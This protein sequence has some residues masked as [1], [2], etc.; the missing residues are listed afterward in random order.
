[1]IRKNTYENMGNEIS[2]SIG[3][4]LYDNLKE[5][6]ELKESFGNVFK[7]DNDMANSSDLYTTVLAKAIYYKSYDRFQQYFD[8]V[9]QLTPADL[10]MPAGAGVYKIPKIVGT[11][12]VKIADG[13]VV[14]YINDG[15]D[16]ITLETETY[17]IGTKMTR[18]ILLRGAKGFIDKLLT[19]G[20]DGVM[21]AVVTD[22]VN[23]MAAAV[24]TANVVTGGTSYTN[25]EECRKLI[26]LGKNSNDVLFGFY[27][28]TLLL[29]A[30]GFK[31]LS[32]SEDFK[33]IWA[34]A[35]NIG[36]A[37]DSPKND[38]RIWGGLKV[39]EADLLTATVDDKTV[40]AII[41]DAKNF[42]VYLQETALETF[43]GRLPGT[44]GDKEVIMA[45]D[46][47]YSV[48]SAEAGACITAA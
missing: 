35:M 5:D 39:V 36:N 19:A 47:G 33:T 37:G 27:P 8:S 29:S 10:G 16:S 48:L 23:G 18:R 6:A 28:D 44:A 45:L 41:V 40:E 3:K 34:R 32:I 9:W 2:E 7:E 38:I 22:L 11:T 31:T 46:A 1:M 24:P 17:G 13:E 15:K 14:D 26:K 4:V 42:M 25:I 43:D 21:R 12:G 20:S 30:S